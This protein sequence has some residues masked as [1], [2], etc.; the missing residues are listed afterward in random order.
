VLICSR[1]V[2]KRVDAAKAR[3]ESLNPLV[4]V[5]TVPEEPQTDAELDALFE[6]VDLVCLTDAPR[7]IC[8]RVFYL[9]SRKRGG[10]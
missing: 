6:R 1:R 4:T 3:I 10:S 8:V 9:F 7:D 5:D 2:F